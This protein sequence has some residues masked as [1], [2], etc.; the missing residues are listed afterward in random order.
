MSFSDQERISHAARRL[1]LGVEPTILAEARSTDEAV[2]MATDLSIPTPQPDN[3]VVPEGLD[4]AKSMAQREAPFRYWLPQMI[5]GPRRIEERL[6]WFWHDHFATS[7]KKVRASYLMFVQHLT[8]RQHATG[9][10]ADLLYAIATDPAMLVYLDGNKNRAN[11]LNENFGR[12]VMEIFTLGIGNY[13]EDDVLAATAAFSGWTIA[14]PGRTSPSGAGP[15]E[16]TFIENFHDATTHTFLGVTRS[17]DAGSAVDA[18]LE[19]PATAEFIATK[20]HRELV[21]LM[22]TPAALTRIAGAFRRDYSIMALV[23]AI[24]EEEAFWSD[25]A[26]RAK[27]RTPLERL[28]GLVQVFGLAL[29]G[30]PAVEIVRWLERLG[31]APFNPP[32]V[33]GFPAGH[34]LLGPYH[35]VHGFDLATLL[36]EVPD[37]SSSQELANRMGLFDLTPETVSV[38]EASS[39]TP[40]Q[41]ALVVNSPEYLTT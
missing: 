11:E 16:A 17:H 24:I 34:R 26:V 22:P 41:G 25:E 28:I 23:S 30:R 35:L 27:V 1:G 6:T 31:F 9:N 38:L 19:Q 13:T 15:G 21:G 36:P 7:V 33:A 8:I 29:E 3:L 5:G 39:G 37:W 4:E 32:N 40:L 12:E 14:R 20:L 2:V 10:F 18:I